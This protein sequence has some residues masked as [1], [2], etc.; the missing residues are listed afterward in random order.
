MGSEMC[1]RD[2]VARAAGRMAQPPR[3][4]HAARVDAPVKR[5]RAHPFG[6]PFPPYTVQE[7]LMADVYRCLEEGGVGVFESPTGTGKSLSL[8]CSTMR[9]LLDQQAKD[10]EG[11]ARSATAAPSGG[12]PSW[13][14]EQAA[15]SVQQ[16]RSQALADSME[17]RRLRAARVASYD[18]ADRALS[19]GTSTAGR[20]NG[21]RHHPDKAL[22][23]A[24][25]MA[26]E[27]G[28]TSADFL[29]DWNE[30]GEGAAAETID[31]RLLADMPDE[32]EDDA[33]HR[34]QVF[35]SSRTHSQ[36]AQVVGEVKKTG[37][38]TEIGVVT[39]GSR[40]NL[41][42]NDA[43][44]GLDG[45]RLNEACLDMQDEAAKERQ[46]AAVEDGEVD[47]ENLGNGLGMGHGAKMLK[48]KKGSDASK[49]DKKR[50]GC[51]YLMGGE[52]R[53]AR[54]LDRL[55]VSPLE[56][57]ELAALGRRENSCPYYAARAALSEAHLVA[58]P[59]PSLLNSSTRQALGIRLAGSIVVIDEAHN[60]IDTIN[61]MH[62]VMLSARHLSET[63][64]Q[65][66][67]Y[68]ERYRSR[69][70]P[71]NRQMVQQLL[72]VVRAL[73]RALLP[74]SSALTRTVPAQGQVG[75]DAPM[76]TGIPSS[77]EGT[78]ERIVAVNSFLCSH[79]IDHINLLR[80]KTFCEISELAK[81]LQ[82]FSDS[83]TQARMQC[84]LTSACRQPGS[85]WRNDER[86]C[87]LPLAPNLPHHSA[88]RSRHA[89]K[90]IWQKRPRSQTAA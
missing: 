49:R 1:I 65:L 88:C 81:K 34:Q 27:P 80:L 6:F 72:F 37:Y 47:V 9:W 77:G 70:K 10:A 59:Y 62:S 17:R 15:A 19:D 89:I 35:Y 13:V 14:E 39:L 68:E 76:P 16:R 71:A 42:I 5:A 38:R 60:L 69:L 61:E 51:P 63:S 36:L 84:T 29:V 3:G 90:P 22:L 73:R 48:G 28:G 20:T 44:R 18:A 87:V 24:E 31:P 67:Q 11:S 86:F 23:G 66:A 64:A 25:T 52:A 7:S 85:L 45:A 26:G 83:Q 21:R 50:S 53:Q 2:R 40:K 41:C 4:S 58:L 12:D 75:A 33:A 74:R 46:A 78:E 43:L 54:V 55:L 56:I 30:A 79:N 57:E 82:G 32:N 8:I